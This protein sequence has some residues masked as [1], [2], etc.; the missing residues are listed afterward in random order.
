MTPPTME[1]T[2]TPTAIMMIHIVLLG[3]AL[4]LTVSRKVPGMNP[5]CDMFAVL[6]VLFQLR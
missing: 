2:N 6:S 5:Y 1:S 4:P 3:L